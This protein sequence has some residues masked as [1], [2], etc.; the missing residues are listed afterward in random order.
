MYNGWSVIGLR[1]HKLTHQ[2][3]LTVQYF[4]VSRLLC[5]CVCLCECICLL[6]C[7]SRVILPYFSV[8]GVLWGFTVCSQSPLIS[9]TTYTNTNA[10]GP[11]IRPSAACVLTHKC[12][13]STHC[14]A[15][16]DTWE[17]Y[18]MSRVYIT[19]TT[20]NY[21]V[22]QRG[23]DRELRACLGEGLT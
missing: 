20:D 14:M 19:K 6:K 16:K 8:I 1:T 2:K 13:S 7:R 23:R 18:C 21:S 5:L 9:S 22:W 12:V 3:Y 17:A 10:Q 11:D 4:L 15:C